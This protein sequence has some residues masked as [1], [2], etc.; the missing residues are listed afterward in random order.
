MGEALKLDAKRQKEKA[1]KAKEKAH[2]VSGAALKSAIER[3]NKAKKTLAKAETVV[4]KAQSHHDNTKLS[5]GKSE[6]KVEADPFRAKRA[7]E[8]PAEKEAKPTL[9]SSNDVEE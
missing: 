8:K 2:A 5:A 7:A 4:D 9:R 1:R 3:R 6:A